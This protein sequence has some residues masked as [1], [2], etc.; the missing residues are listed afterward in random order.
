[1]L[2]QT[3]AVEIAAPRTDPI[4][5]A[6]WR[7]T[8]PLAKKATPKPRPFRVG[9]D[10][11]IATAGDVSGR[12]LEDVEIFRRGTSGRLVER[13]KAPSATYQKGSW[14]LQQPQI[15]RFTNGEALASS[16]LQMDW[17]A[18]LKPVDVQ[19]LLS[20]EGSPTAASARRALAGGG[21]ERPG[22]YY[23]V[24]VQ[25]AFAG[26]VGILV[27]LLLTAP[28]ALGNFRNRQ[29]AIL[30]AAGLGAGLAFLVADGLLAALGESA[31]LSP[32]LAAWT[33]PL[34]FAALAT[35]VLLKMEG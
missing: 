33:A 26:P 14:L 10:L 22:S 15:V 25:Q 11:V 3:V 28:V 35:T 31:A 7:D 21:S 18:R 4:L 1:M 13:I 29:G 12:R 17:P 34:V 8:A 2:I 23:A 5:Q 6:W 19:V 16:A 9:D 20:A 24:R 30:T 27:M 32:V